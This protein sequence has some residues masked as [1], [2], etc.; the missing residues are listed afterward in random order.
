MA[1]NMR[2]NIEVANG[3]EDHVGEVAEV[4]ISGGPVFNDFDNTVK[5][6]T[7]GIGQVP[8]GEG[9]DVI[10]VISYR[11][12]ELAQRGN[13]TTQRGGYPAFEELLRRGTITI[14]PDVFELV[15]EHPGAVNAAI[16]V[17]QAVEEAGM[18]LG[19][20]SG[21]HAE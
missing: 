9:D 20:I 2:R 5:A 21:M 14:I 6:L 4:T 1:G 18:S 8:V 11:T 16:G 15:L 19:A 17:A 10:E 3:Q 13:T 12:D 7:D